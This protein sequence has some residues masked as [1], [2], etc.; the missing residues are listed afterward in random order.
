MA[1]FDPAS[2]QRYR[3]GYP[4]ELFALLNPF[5]G[6]LSGEAVRVADLGAGT[7]IS[8][9]SFLRHFPAVSAMCL[10]DPDPRMLERADF[11]G[12]FPDLRVQRVCSTAEAFSPREP[13]D[14]ILIGSAWHWMN[15]H[16]VLDQVI[17]VLRPG[18]FLLVF[19]Y[20]FP[21]AI[22]HARAPEL[23]EWVRRQFNQVWRAPGQTPRG[24]LGELLEPVRKHRDFAWRG[25]RSLLQTQDLDATEFEG[26]VV[27]QS[28]YLAHESTL[29]PAQKSAEREAMREMLSGF[30]SPSVLIPFEY[31]YEA[32]VFQARR[33]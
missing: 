7:G 2:Y 20:Q 3:V 25:S 9:A 12:E 24:S 21:K 13:V 18:G 8:A 28:R 30:W 27:S 29:S 23:N 22:G 33:P 10:S 31:R 6:P 19:E 11:S 26:V 4:S 14:G 5:L 15:P 32:Q 1:R 16:L 17:R